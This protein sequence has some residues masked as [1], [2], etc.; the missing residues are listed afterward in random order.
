VSGST[1]QVIEILEARQR[2]D[3]TAPDFLHL[4]EWRFVAVFS[5]RENAET[6][7]I[8]PAPLRREWAIAEAW[9]SRELSPP[10]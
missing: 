10:R 8:S 4:E 3:A 6:P 2:V 7:G 5:I 1:H 9:L